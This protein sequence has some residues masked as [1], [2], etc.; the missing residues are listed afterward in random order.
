M[1]SSEEIKKIEDFVYSKPRSIQEIAQLL[2]KNWRTAD[3]YV[4]E[5]E[6][7]YGTITTRIF[8]KDT[9]GALK[10]VYWSSVEK[11]S[12]SIFQEQLE[13]EIM[14]GK[15]KED[16]SAFDIYQHV[17]NKNKKLYSKKAINEDNAGNLDRFL[18]ML[19]AAKKQVLFFS[20][21][22]SFIHTKTKTRRIFDTIEQ[23]VKK[24]I[25]I[26][27]ICRIDISGRDNVEELL[28]L[29][30]KYKKQLIEIRNRKQPLRATIIDNEIIDIK[31]I[32]EPTGKVKEL[33]KRLFIFYTIKDKEWAEWMSKIFW[34]MF[35]QSIGAEKRLEELNKFR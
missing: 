33:D 27:V 12:N 5:I 3:R 10:I 24:G 11:I 4:Q 17:S 29:N 7:N 30:F 1:L 9:R 15:E 32:I 13:Q 8:R 16:F 34:K 14:Q 35:S 21:N 19:I 2:N 23:L 25:P 31:E 28:S 26:K 18:D 6:K 20:G 22:L